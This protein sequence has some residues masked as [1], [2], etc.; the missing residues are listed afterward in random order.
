MIKFTLIKNQVAAALQMV[1][2]AVDKKQLLPVLSSMLVRFENQ[3]LLL[4]ATDLEIELTASIEYD[5][6]SLN[7]P[8]LIPAKKILDVLKTLDDHDQLTM[9]INESQ[10]LIQCGRSQFKFPSLSASS[11]PLIQNTEWTQ[12]LSMPRLSLIRLLE[13]TVFCVSQQD[14]RVFLNALLFECD[15][16]G[17]TTVGADGHRMAISKYLFSTQSSKERYLFPRKGVNELLRLLNTIQEDTVHINLNS[18]LFRVE[19]QSYVFTSKLVDAQY[20]PYQQALPR[21]LETFVLIDGDVLKRALARIMIV[22]HDR[23]RPV[24]IQIEQ[25]QFSLLASNQEQE[26]VSEIVE[27]S[28]DG[29]DIKIGINPSYLLDVLNVFKTGTI[30]LS[31]NTPDSSILVEFLADELFQYIMMPMKL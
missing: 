28:V 6:T 8:F 9:T 20:L 12:T 2:N 19:T 7:E 22:A 1:S 3:K 13:N 25:Q 14:I 10:L 29:P 23:S 18:Q 4:T 17:V 30:R 31:L 15:E 26:E 27:A 11:F 21:Q 24:V 5:T 16:Q